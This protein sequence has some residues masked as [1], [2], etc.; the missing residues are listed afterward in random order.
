MK[1][2]RAATTTLALVALAACGDATDRP[3]D[4]DLPATE[5]ETAAPAV[6]EWVQRV[7]MVANAIEDRVVAADSI[8]AANDMTRSEFESRLYD[9]AADPVLTA[10]YE[11]ARAR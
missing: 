7:A 4:A 3:S 8:L 1:L 6:P 2:F 11:G 9:I 10:A 5:T